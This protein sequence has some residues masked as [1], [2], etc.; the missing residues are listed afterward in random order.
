MLELPSLSIGLG[1]GLLAGAVVAG[2]WSASRIRTQVQGRLIEA[3]ERAQR[4]E[5]EA[6]ELRKQLTAEQ[7]DLVHSRDAL[8]AA[9][10][11]RAVA[12]IPGP[13]SRAQP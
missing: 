9:Q 13:G 2:F 8:S 5:V 10:Q 11:A 6:A 3:A 7:A 1:L 12:E 4:A